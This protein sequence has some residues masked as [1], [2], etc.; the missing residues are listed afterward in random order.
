MQAVHVKILSLPLLSKRKKM[1]IKTNKK[2]QKT[3]K[4]NKM[5][6][7]HGKNKQTNLK[8]ICIGQLLL[9]IEHD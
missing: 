9:G 8:S 3:P 2:Y 6:Q 4:Q 1:T 7:T 5:K